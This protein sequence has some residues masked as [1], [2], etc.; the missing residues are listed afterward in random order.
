MKVILDELRCDGHGTC[1]DAC[2]QV[3]ALGDDDE[4]V[5]ILND[6]PPEEL[7]DAVRTA[8]RV[9]PKAALTLSD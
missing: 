3:F 9:C 7:R 8:V 1:V 2:P 5:T 4:I 6:A